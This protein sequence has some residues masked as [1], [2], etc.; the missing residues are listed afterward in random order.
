MII[1]ETLGITWS[2]LFLE[3]QDQNIFYLTYTANILTHP[4]E[5]YTNPHNSKKSLPTPKKKDPPPNI[6]NTPLLHTATSTQKRRRS[7]THSIDA[8]STAKSR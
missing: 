7:Q 6:T 1:P 5:T 4:L 2:S 3:K 8:L